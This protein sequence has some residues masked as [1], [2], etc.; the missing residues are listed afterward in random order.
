MTWSLTAQRG[1]IPEIDAS[2]TKRND[3]ELTYIVKPDGSTSTIADDGEA[4]FADLGDLYPMD[5][6]RA[7]VRFHRSL[8]GKADAPDLTP[9]P[10]E[11]LST[12]TAG[13]APVDLGGTR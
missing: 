7:I 8:T 13:P 5:L 6:G 10:V 12:S 1:H 11:P 2:M 4:M 9:P 3:A